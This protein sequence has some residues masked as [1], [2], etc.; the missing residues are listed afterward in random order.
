[1][2]F[3]SSWIILVIMTILLAG[4]R[5]VSSTTS[6]SVKTNNDVT[7][8]GFSLVDESAL[9]EKQ[10]VHKLKKN[11]TYSP[12]LTIINGLEQ[13][14]NYKI[15]FLLDYERISVYYEGQAKKQIDLTLPANSEANFEVEIPNIEEGIHD[16]VVLVV[17]QS[18]RHLNESFY[19]PPEEIHMKR[20]TTVVVGKEEQKETVYKEMTNVTQR[21]VLELNSVFNPFISLLPEKDMSQAL[22]LI[23]KEQLN[24]LWLNIPCETENSYFSVVVFLN[25]KQVDLNNPFIQSSSRGV[26]HVPLD[27]SHELKGNIKKQNNL[28]VAV[29]E[30]PYSIPF[31]DKGVLDLTNW[32]VKLTNKITV[33]N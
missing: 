5:D 6:F 32:E 22:S 31:D 28:V 3:K 26:L 27:L 23:K 25:N 33:L 21:S 18:D 7:G 13:S 14:D 2:Y 10:L 4:C 11:E 29:I 19:V 1:M 17:K 15:F 8:S 9:S 24:N 12:K 20:R 30:N 16:F